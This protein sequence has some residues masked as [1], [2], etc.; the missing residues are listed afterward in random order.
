MSNSDISEIVRAA[1]Q[2]ALNTQAQALEQQFQE[3][4]GRIGAI[5]LTNTEVKAYE[6]ISIDT[7]I[8]CEEPLDVV[9]SIPEFDGKQEN[10]VSWRQAANAAYTVFK[11]FNGSSRHYQAVAIIRNKIRGNADAVLAS[12]N[13]VLNFEAIVAR[14][15]FTYADKTRVRVI[16]QQLGTMRQG[17]LSLN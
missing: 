14:L 4:E 15:D 11:P 7:S 3:L 8:K 1:V 5:S 13:T 17:E 9:K 10:Y 2:A 6:A 16:Q 12:F